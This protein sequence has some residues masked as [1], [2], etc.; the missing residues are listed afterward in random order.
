MSAGDKG[1]RFLRGLFAFAVAALAA[2]C[3]ASLSQSWFTLQALQGAGAEL[4]GRDWLRTMAHDLHGLAFRG[5]VVS[6]GPLLALALAI[7][8]A[9]AGR[10]R[11][12]V[13][14]SPWWLYP[15]AGALGVALL[16]LIAHRFAMGE[17][18]LSATRTR[19]AQFSQ[20]MAGALGGVVF[21]WLISRAGGRSGE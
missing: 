5:S 12:I 9:A 17:H 13:A 6:Y 20:V 3:V 14:C 4:Q 21:A 10:V 16:L 18:V 1:A 19:A 8:F 7:A 15:L 2:H 11:R